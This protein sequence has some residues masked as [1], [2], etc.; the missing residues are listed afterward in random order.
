[1]RE[2]LLALL[3][4]NS[5][6]GISELAVLLGKEEI[7]ILI[8]AVDYLH[9]EGIDITYPKPSPCG[10]Y[11]AYSMG[12]RGYFMPFNQESDIWLLDL[13]TMQISRPE[14][15]NSN[16]SESNHNWSSNGK[17]LV[18]C[19]KYPDRLF[20]KP[21]FAHFNPQTGQFDKR[22]V[23][24]QEDPDFYERYTANFNNSDFVTGTVPVS[25]FE[26]RDVVRGELKT[27]NSKS[28]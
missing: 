7:E 18:T 8:P 14:G 15:I 11:I 28:Y 9:R 17:W 3:E 20:T 13:Q 10:R 23:L 16:S 4:K 25:Q 27:V 19:S 5:R 26:I 21:F 22:F 12:T 6:I 2:Q 1:M 24:P